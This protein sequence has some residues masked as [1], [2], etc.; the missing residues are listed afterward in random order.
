MSVE[1]VQPFQ[2]QASTRSHLLLHYGRPVLEP[3]SV[4]RQTSWTTVY[5]LRS[6]IT[7]KTHRMRSLTFRS[8]VR[9]EQAEARLLE[10]RLLSETPDLSSLYPGRIR[11]TMTSP[12]LSA[13]ISELTRTKCSRFLPVLTPSI[14]RSELRGALQIPVPL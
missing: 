4:S 13:Q 7:S 12:I 14:R 2:A 10:I 3:M 9:W 8:L 5:T 11:P 1:T 6:I